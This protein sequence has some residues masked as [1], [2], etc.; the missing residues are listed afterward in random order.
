GPRFRPVLITAPAAGVR[1]LDGEELEVLLPVRALFLERHGTEAGLHPFHAAVRQLAR[2]GHVVLVF[3]A[4]HR[5]RAERAVV[6]RPSERDRKY[7][8]DSSGLTLSTAPSMRT[9]RSWE[10]QKKRR[11]ARLFSM[12]SRALRLS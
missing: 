8:V 12:M 9:W 10:G 7:A 6:D 11:L 5:P 1:V 4:R 3:I 2:A